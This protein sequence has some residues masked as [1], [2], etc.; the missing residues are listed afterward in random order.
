MIIS[1]TNPPLP[2][3]FGWIP[4]ENRTAQQQNKHADI[5]TEVGEFQL[6]RQTR[7]TERVRV[8]LWDYVKKILGKHLI[9][10]LQETGSCVA[11]GAW[12]GVMYL[13]YMEIVRL[14]ESEMVKIIFLPYHYGRGR[15]YAGIYGRGEG[16]TGSGQSKAVTEG[17]LAQDAIADLPKPIEKNGA[18]TWT[19]R[20]EMEWSDGARIPSSTIEIA[21]HNP[22]KSTALVTSYQKV[23][24]AIANGYPVT[25]ASNQGFQGRFVADKG[26][27]WG[28]PG[29]QWAHQMC[30]IGVDDDPARPGCYCLNSWGPDA[31]PAPIDDAPP[32]GFWVDADVVDRMVRQ[33]DSFAYSQFDGFPEQLDFNVVR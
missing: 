31:H 3:M 30:F 2:S 8:V 14:G 23:R 4:H 19:G 15:F 26:K 18:L 25:V 10:L 6:I 20:V 12:N 11:N 21:K 27:M 32:G 9:T 7:S 5:V 13:M 16:S 33:G 28:G 17:V 1:D 22:V 29:G 24:D